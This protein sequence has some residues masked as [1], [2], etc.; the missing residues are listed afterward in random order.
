MSR[1]LLVI[2]LE[3]DLPLLFLVLRLFKRFPLIFTRHAVG[4]SLFRVV[5]FPL[6]KQLACGWPFALVVWSTFISEE[7]GIVFL[8]AMRAYGRF[9]FESFAIFVDAWP[10]FL[11]FFW[12]GR[13]LLFHFLEHWLNLLWVAWGVGRRTH[14][15]PYINLNA[16]AC[17]LLSCLQ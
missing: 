11:A 12:R 13:L 4:C 17:R 8:C 9:R 6:L 14:V 2:F 5:C 3:C 7:S 10:R 16:S 1:T 15:L